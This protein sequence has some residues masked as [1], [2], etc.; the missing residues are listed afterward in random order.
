MKK[1]CFSNEASFFLLL[2]SKKKVPCPEPQ[3][4][5]NKKGR[6]IAALILNAGFIL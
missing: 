2:I 5:S 4:A 6:K 3:A 1:G